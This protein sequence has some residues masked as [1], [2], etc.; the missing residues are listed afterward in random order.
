MGRE[1]QIIKELKKNDYK[2]FDEFYNL[3]SRL[4]YYVIAT[5]IKN[6]QT[7][8]DLM[9]DTYLKFLNNISSVNPNQNPNAYLAQIA[10]NLAIN[11]FNKQKRVVVDD[12]YFTNLKDSKEHEDFGIDLGIIN[13][14]ETEEKEIV[15]LKLIGNLKYREIAS[16]LNK[17]MGT[18]QW[19]YN[20][21]IKKLRKK[22]GEKNE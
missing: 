15:T 10:K 13:Y 16:L 7:I 17:P 1:K 21:A 6:R 5:V 2:S 22:V 8:E 12:S 4:V 9:Q 18:V 11:E 3:T 19:I 14:L 20:N